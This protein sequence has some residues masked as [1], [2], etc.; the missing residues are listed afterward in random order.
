[1]MVKLASSMRVLTW[2]VNGLATTLQYY[3]W[4]ETKSYKVK[5]SI[6]LSYRCFINLKKVLLDALESDIIWQ[7]N[8]FLCHSNAC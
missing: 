4:S 3:P 1:M 2:N 7:A 6:R 5:I 8:R